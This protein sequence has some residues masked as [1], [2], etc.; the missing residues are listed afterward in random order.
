MK[1]FKQIVAVI[2]FAVAFSGCVSQSDYDN[3][4]KQLLEYDKQISDLKKDVSE[5][6]ATIKELNRNITEID[7]ENVELRSNIEELNR[8]IDVLN[9]KIDELE[10]GSS[11]L[12]IEIKNTYESGNYQKTISLADEFHKKYNGTADD[13]EAQNLRNKAQAALDKEEQERQQEEERKKAEAAKSEK[14]RVHSLIRVYNL[15]VDDIDSVGG[16]DVKISWVNNSDK[17]IK[18]IYFDVKAYNAVGDAVE[19]E[20]GGYMVGNLKDTGPYNHGEGD[21]AGGI[22]ENVWYNNTVVRLEFSN[23][24][25]EYMDGTKETISDDSLQ[26]VIY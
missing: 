22:W 8:D 2:C 6:D 7:E 23:I 15:T 11:R 1:C 25:I 17:V 4:E 5:K 9:E 16:V 26:Y 20:I 18:Y 14:E 13:I 12:L 19:S 24:L 10:N 21:I 3:M